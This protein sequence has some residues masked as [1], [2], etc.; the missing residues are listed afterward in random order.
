MSF[1]A[2]PASVGELEMAVSSEGK[3]SACSKSMN[4]DDK[5]LK[6][7]GYKKE[8]Y[9]GL[10]AFS[11]FAFGFT[12]VS[13]L[14]SFVSMY[15]Y[16]LA[17]GGPAVILWGFIITFLFNTI[18]AY[19]MAEICSAY[20]S[21]GSVYHWTGQL[22]PPSLAPLASYTCG[23]S[24][25]LGNAAGDAAF[26]YA[27]ATF[28]SASMSISGG[29][30]LPQQMLC[31]VSIAVL[32]VWSLLNFFRIDTVGSFNNLAVFAHFGAIIFILLSCFIVAEPLKSTEWVFTAYINDTGFSS[33]VYVSLMGVLTGVYCFTG[34]EASAHMAEE[35]HGSRISAPNGVINT[36]LATG[37]GGLLV[38]IPILYA[39][40]NVD[41]SLHGVTGNAV[42]DAVAFSMNNKWASAFVW[43]VTVNLFFAGVSSVA[44]TGRITW[45]LMRDKGFF[46]SEYLSVVD[47]TLRSPIRAI[48]FVFIFD[49]MLL[50]LPLNPGVGLTAF[51]SIVGLCAV[52]FSVSY[53]IPIGS[54]L[55]FS[56][57]ESFPVTDKSL[58][59]YSKPF[60]FI[61][62]AWLLFTAILFFFPT[63]YPVTNENMNWLFAVVLFVMVV[64]ILNW[65]FNSQYSFTGPKRPENGG[66]VVP[67]PKHDTDGSLCV[68]ANSVT[69]I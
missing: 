1:N 29:T 50:L 10:S 43:A 6:R 31:L 52:G 49:A 57:P 55:I 22:V 66:G 32:F 34:F 58:G 9:R 48:M 67:Q 63:E 37:V 4:E 53:A 3:R 21:A 2:T 26:S 64:G 18:V 13:V 27:W 45:A 28:L 38:I 15:G 35:T 7:L 36:V 19:S 61:S 25:F 17:T 42:V 16:G 59:V 30:H 68:N 23:W 8:L 41:E 51:Y 5:I 65:I 12:E 62:C 39:T 54:H 60:G 40:S 69:N 46:Y 24:N 47:P 33:D 56:T 11:N 44:V 14:C 20:P